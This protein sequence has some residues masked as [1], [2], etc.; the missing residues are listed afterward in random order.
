VKDTPE[1][2]ERGY[3]EALAAHY[4]STHSDVLAQQRAQDALKEQLRRFMDV[5]DLDELVDGETG[6]GVELGPAPRTTT[7]DVRT[8]PDAVVLA[9]ARRGVLEVNTRAFDALRKAGGGADLDDAHRHHRMTGE[10]TRPLR[11]RA[12]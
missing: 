10:G 6:L 12:D 2:W 7:W 8:M 5:N 1:T 4:A 3:A 11:V 9:L